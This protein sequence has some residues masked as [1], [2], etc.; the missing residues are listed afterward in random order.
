MLRR[1]S[2]GTLGLALLMPLSVAA[3]TGAQDKKPDPERAAGD[4]LVKL[5]KNWKD[6]T[7]EPNLGD[8][9]WKLKMEV[10]V[11]LAQAGRAGFGLLEQAAKEGSKWSAA[12]RELAKESLPILQKDELRK[13]LAD[14]DLAQMDSARVGKLAPDFA[15]TD[16]TG[17]TYRLSQFRDKI[18]VLTFIIFDT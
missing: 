10:L 12:T 2:R 5:D 4:A 9:R 11:R 15:L 17:D 1:L 7:N 14:Y 6:Y 18:V 16:A 3:Q 13:A 8:P